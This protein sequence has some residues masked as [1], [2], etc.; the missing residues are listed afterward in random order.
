M[1]EVYATNKIVM[2][3][4]IHQRLRSFHVNASSK[5]FASC[6][7]RVLKPSVNQL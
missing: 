1:R 4:I 3:Y 7:S 6:R 5:A 2:D